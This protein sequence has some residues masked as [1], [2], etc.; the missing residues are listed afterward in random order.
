M[1]RLAIL[2][3]AAG[4]LA[5]TG[6]SIAL[7]KGGSHGA[8]NA[9]SNGNSN[10]NSGG[11]GNPGGNGASNSNSGGNGN[12]GGS[13]SNAGGGGSSGGGAADSGQTSSGSPNGGGNSG[14]VTLVDPCVLNVGTSC[15]F[16]GN[17]NLN[18]KLGEV[19]DAYNGQTPAPPVLLSLEGLSQGELD[20]GF[21]D[22]HFGAVTADFLVSYYA[23][24]GG[25]GFRLYEVAPTFTFN[26]ST[27]GLV[28]GGGNQPAVSHV[29]WLG[30]PWTPPVTNPPLDPPLDPPLTPPG[31]FGI[32]PVPEPATWSLMIM[33][34]GMAGAMFRHQ[35]RKLIA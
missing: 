6:P 14:V 21:S 28:N 7:A 1:K 26:W 33:G 8:G 11:A 30:S 16:Q 3:C 35:R 23:V 29:I 17:I 34:F 4:A 10:G 2:M 9:N 31:G 32:H 24:K 27:A 5:L 25:D 18:N 20:S 12:S 13:N 22:P 19:E 15:Y